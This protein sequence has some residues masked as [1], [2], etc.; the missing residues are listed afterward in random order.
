MLPVSSCDAFGVDLK[1][2]NQAHVSTCLQALAEWAALADRFAAT[3]PGGGSSPPLLAAAAE[4][5]LALLSRQAQQLADPLQLEVPNDAQQADAAAE[6]LS[7]DELAA[8]VRQ[9]HPQLFRF[10][11]D[12]TSGSSSSS[13][14]GGTQLQVQ[15]AQALADVLYRQQRLK[16]EPFEWV[17]EGLQPLLLP[18]RLQRRK[19][20]PLSLA[21]VA[22]AV[23]WRLGLPLLPVPAEPDA[24]VAAGLQEG[25]AGTATAQGALP[26]QQLRPDVVQR[27]ASRASAAAPEAGPWLLLLP[28]VVWQ[29]QFVEWHHALDACTGQL[30]DAAEAVRRYPALQQPAGP[31][32]LSALLGWQHMVRTVIQVGAQCACIC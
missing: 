11:S 27:Y 20:A 6:A 17:Y 7:L 32:L 24:E 22:A 18:P 30:V 2:A 9:Q 25:P 1:H 8:A 21:T 13:G 26:L 14:A 19:L 15:Q 23:A 29:Q 31:R 12:G 3:Q 16:H 5:G 28:D 10:R 4:A